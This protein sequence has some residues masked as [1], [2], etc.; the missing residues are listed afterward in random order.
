MARPTWLRRLIEIIDGYSSV[1]E[2]LRDLGMWGPLVTAGLAVW[3]YVWAKSEG[4]SV[5]QRAV[6]AAAVFAI[7]IVL[8]FVF[9]VW[10][11]IRP[12]A[13]PEDLMHSHLRDLAFRIVDLARDDQV[14]RNRTF[15]D[16]T[17]Y[18]P[19]ILVMTDGGIG[20]LDSCSFDTPDL[21]T[22]FVEVLPDQRFFGAV[23]LSG[24]LFRR[25]RF[26][27]IQIASDAA[28]IA[29]LSPGFVVRN[30]PTP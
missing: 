19:A 26:I 15:E 24:C 7:G 6:L 12:L 22:T 28:G 27:K 8:L 10:M 5:S 16:C 23:G 17:I 25:C 30:A 1:R 18:G 2:A 3:T 11:R 9:R 21:K 14:I 13:L 29:K 4:L 20:G